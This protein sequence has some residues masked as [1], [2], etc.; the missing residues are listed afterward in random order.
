MKWNPQELKNRDK[1]KG[2][3]EVQLTAYK[4]WKQLHNSFAKY[5]NISIKHKKYHENLVRYKVILSISR[6]NQ[7]FLNAYWHAT[8]TYLKL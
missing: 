6:K 7:G 4:N 3:K 2:E 5:K 1:T 8:F